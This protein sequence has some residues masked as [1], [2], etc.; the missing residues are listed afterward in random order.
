MVVVFN[1]VKFCLYL[2]SYTLDWSFL[3]FEYSFH[4]FLS[5]FLSFF[6][7]NTFNLSVEL[8]LTLNV[9]DGCAPLRGVGGPGSV[10]S[11]SVLL[12]FNGKTLTHTHTHT[13]THKHEYT[14]T[15]RILERKT[16]LLLKK[17]KSGR[18]IDIEVG[19]H[20]MVFFTTVSYFALYPSLFR[21]QYYK[22]DLVF[23]KN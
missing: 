21:I 10:R 19:S 4:L 22:I 11:S 5:F 8:P 13:L 3:N 23:K 6:H 17:L 1:C 15:G 20:C 14:Q 7:H 9:L 12:N 18:K 2:Y 16:S